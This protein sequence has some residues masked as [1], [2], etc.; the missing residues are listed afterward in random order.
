MWERQEAKNC[1]DKA[2]LER[3]KSKII[4]DSTKSIINT[5]KKLS[6]S[7]INVL[8]AIKKLGDKSKQGP[9]ILC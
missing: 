2:T 7:P 3:I 4:E 1:A 9:G 5:G 6:I 8:K